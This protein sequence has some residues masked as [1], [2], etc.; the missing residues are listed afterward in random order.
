MPTTTSSG[1]I[2]FCRQ[3]HGET[4]CRSRARLFAISIPCRS[5][6]AIKMTLSNTSHQQTV[7]QWGKLGVL[8]KFHGDLLETWEKDR[9]QGC[10]F[11]RD[12]DPSLNESAQ[13]HEYERFGN[14]NYAA[15]MNIWGAHERLDKILKKYDPQHIPPSRFSQPLP[16]RLFVSDLEVSAFFANLVSAL[17]AVVG[18]VVLVY[19]FP[20]TLRRA[21]WWPLKKMLYNM[22]TP[23]TE[24]NNPQNNKDKQKYNVMHSQNLRDIVFQYTTK[25]NVLVDYRNS[26]T[27]RTFFGTIFDKEGFYL[28]KDANILPSLAINPLLEM[29]DKGDF[30]GLV[31]L[32]N[33][34]FS[35]LPLHNYCEV[36]YYKV[37]E[38]IELVYEQVVQT[39]QIRLSHPSLVKNPHKFYRFSLK[40]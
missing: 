12:K 34:L 4:P 23:W 24:A 28:P 3:R 32:K 14:L 40:T 25:I 9:K 26:F 6:G 20:I 36:I 13:L 37:R 5:E 11:F 22:S 18:Q 2:G 1:T 10:P 30:E 35:S 8:L 31:R 16:K 27:H 17:D 33:E 7:N 19:G 21:G 29:R 38:L 15:Q 39:Y